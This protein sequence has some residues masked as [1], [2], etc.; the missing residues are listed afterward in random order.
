MDVLNDFLNWAWARHEHPV[1]WHVRPLSILPFLLFCV[2]EER[3]GHSADS[4]G[5]AF[6]S[7]S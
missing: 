4:G 6:A 1:S 7:F 2:Q 5:C 3:P